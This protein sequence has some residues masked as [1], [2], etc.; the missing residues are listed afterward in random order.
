[1]GKILRIKYVGG[2]GMRILSI[3]WTTPFEVKISTKTGRA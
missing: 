3:A 2:G 1:M